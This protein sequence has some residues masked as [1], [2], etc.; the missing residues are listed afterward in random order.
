MPLDATLT[1]AVAAAY[2]FVVV[3]AI[4]VAARGALRIDP[5]IAR[6]AE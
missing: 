6:R 3:L 2:L 4:A 5:A 1:T